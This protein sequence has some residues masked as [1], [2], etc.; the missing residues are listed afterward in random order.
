MELAVK[1]T[2]VMKHPRRQLRRAIL[3]TLTTIA[4]VI[5]S[6]V[7]VVPASAT[8]STN[9][10]SFAVLITVRGVNAPGGSN[11]QN[12]RVWLT[13]GHGAQLS[14]LASAFANNA[15]FTVFVESLAWN[16]N[17]SSGDSYYEARKN[18]GVSMLVDEINSLHSACSTTNIFLAGHSGGAHIVMDTLV[19]LQNTYAGG[20][21]KGAVVYGDPSNR[22]NQPYRAPGSANA[23]GW[24]WRD[25]AGVA[26]LNTYRFYGWSFDN[27]SNPNP[28][29]QPKVR[30]YCNYNDW[31]CTHGPQMLWGDPA[32]NA[33]TGNT[34]QV[35]DWFMYLV[36]AY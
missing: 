16:A 27:P 3:A 5:A 29:W 30:S 33:Y 10:C 25:D 21:I 23:D 18:Q 17:L 20:R 24:F 6:L 35:T 34:S 11:L 32:H 14:P 28:A 22:A 2:D 9:R 19:S 7:A 36:N 4:C 13:G 8:P 15:P 26:A 12:G 1:G 31:A